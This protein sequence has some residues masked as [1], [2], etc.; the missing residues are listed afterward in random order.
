M[1]RYCFALDLKPD[2]ALVAAY[3]AH[4]RQVWPAVLQSIAESGIVHL[5]IYRW[6]YRL[7]MIMDTRDDF[8]LDAKA[9]A[10]AANPEVQRWEELMWQ[11]Q[12][13]LPGV[14]PGRKWQLMEQ[15]FEC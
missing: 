4:H 15:I 10:D 13:G 7:F 12:Q 8:S 2:D 6:Q 5:Q 3:E 11:Y 14:A 1:R 9:A